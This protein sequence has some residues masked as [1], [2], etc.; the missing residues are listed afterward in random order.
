MDFE[1]QEVV[2]NEITGTCAKVE[3][4]ELGMMGNNAYL[5]SDGE[6]LLVVDPSCECDKIITVLNG[7]KVDAIV[8]T[9]HHYDHV[10]A[11]AELREKTG[12]PTVA[13]PEDA[14]YIDGQESVPGRWPEFDRCPVDILVRDGEELAVGSMK[15]Q[16]IATPG[17]T[18]GSICLF[19]DPKKAGNSTGVPIL[20]AGDTLFYAGT[21]RVDLPGGSMDDMLASLRK[22]SPLPNETIVLPGHSSLTSIGGERKRLFDFLK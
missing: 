3:Q 18:P 10:G 5:I 8:L 22:L 9:H 15:W 12:A 11:A 4:F 7:R 14:P 13:S 1:A 17:H 16:V 20:I 19:L 21:G 2:I 6:G